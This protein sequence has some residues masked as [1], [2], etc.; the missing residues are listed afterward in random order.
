MLKIYTHYIS[1]GV[2]WDETGNEH[3]F[4]HHMLMIRNLRECAAGKR[5]EFVTAAN[6]IARAISFKAS[7]ASPQKLI[8]CEDSDGKSKQLISP[9]E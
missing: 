7:E 4:A 2:G 1:S 9:N 6:D 5:R 8:D 3:P